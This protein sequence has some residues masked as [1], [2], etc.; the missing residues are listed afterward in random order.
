MVE[1]G[2]GWFISFTSSREVENVR[3]RNDVGFVA[4]PTG[5]KYETSNDEG[6]KR[7]K[8]TIFGQYRSSLAI[9]CT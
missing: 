4:T 5:R 6:N 1:R 2:K 8:R 3:I 7:N 9:R